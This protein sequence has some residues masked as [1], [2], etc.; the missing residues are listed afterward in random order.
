M[1]GGKTRGLP[2][3]P[4]GRVPSVQKEIKLSKIYSRIA[5][6]YAFKQNLSPWC[7]A[8]AA[9]KT[10]FARLSGCVT[11]SCGLNGDDEPAGVLALV[12]KART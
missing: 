4:P 2:E 12:G 3:E 8:D 10:G 9:T 11:P 7:E 5:W 1:C 6:T